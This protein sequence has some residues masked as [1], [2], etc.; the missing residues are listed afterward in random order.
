MDSILRPL[1]WRKFQDDNRSRSSGESNNGTISI[2]HSD[3]DEIDGILKHYEAPPSKN[4]AL[5]LVVMDGSE[6]DDAEV[7]SKTTTQKRA[8][9]IT[10]TSIKYE[11][12]PPLETNS[13][14]FTTNNNIHRTAQQQCI[15]EKRNS[16]G[17]QISLPRPSFID[18]IESISSK[19]TVSKIYHP[20][21]NLQHISDT[22]G[23]Y[24]VRI[25]KG[26]QQKGFES[27]LISNTSISHIDDLEE[28]ETSNIH[29]Q[30][31]SNLANIEICNANNEKPIIQH[32]NDFDGLDDHSPI[33]LVDD[34]PKEGDT[35]SSKIVQPVKWRFAN[36]YWKNTSTR[37]YNTSPAVR[38]PFVLLL[39]EK[40]CSSRTAQS[41]EAFKEISAKMKTRPALQG[42]KKPVNRL[43][44][45]QNTPSHSHP[46]SFEPFNLQSERPNKK[47][48]TEQALLSN[49]TGCGPNQ[50]EHEADQGQGPVSQIPIQSQ[51]NNSPHQE[52]GICSKVKA[53]ES[54]TVAEYQAVNDLVKPR[55]EKR[56]RHKVNSDHHSESQGHTHGNAGF[57]AQ[58]T[59]NAK[60]LASNSH[61][62]D[63]RDPISNEEDELQAPHSTSKIVPQVVIPSSGNSHLATAHQAPRSRESELQKSSYVSNSQLERRILSN[64]VQKRRVLGEVKLEDGSEDELSQGNPPE[65]PHVKRIN[66]PLQSP[67]VNCND[68]EDD[69]DMESSRD[70]RGDMTKWGGSKN[71]DQKL[72]QRG[73]G[74]SFRVES[75]FS[76]TIYWL[77]PGQMENWCLTLDKSGVIRLVKDKEI[78]SDFSI[79]ASAI[80][81]IMI[82]RESCKLVIRKPQE[83]GLM[84]DADML[85]E[86]SGILA[87]QNFLESIKLFLKDAEV[88]WVENSEIDQRFLHARENLD[89]RTG[90]ALNKRSRAESQ[91]EDLQLLTSN[92]DRRTAQ[93]TQLVGHE[94]QH[95]Q[96]H[97]L[98]RAK[99]QKIH[100]KMQ[101]P[102]SQQ[103]KNDS[104]DPIE[105]AEFYASSSKTNGTRASLRSAERPK[106]YKPTSEAR[107]PSPERWSEVNKD[108]EKNWEKSV[109]YPKSGKKTATVDKQDIYRLDNGEFLNDNLIMFYLLWLEQQHPEL[110]TRV[111]VH[112]TF[113][114]ASL[115]KA[116]KNKKGINYEA[117]E[118]WTAKVDLLSYDYIIVPVNENTHWYVAIICN[119]PRLLNLEIK[120]SPQPIE[121]DV[122]SEQDGEIELRSASKLTTPS[123][124]PQS[125]PMRSVSDKDE[126]GVDDSFGELSLAQDKQTETPNDLEPAKKFPPSNHGLASASVEMNP[127]DTAVDKFATDV[128]D[129]AQ[130]SSPPAKSN[131]VAKGKRI[132]PIRTYDPK[133]PRIITFDSLALKHSNTCVNL[134]DYMVAEIKAKKS[135]SIIPPKPIGMAAKTQDKDSATG[136]YLGKGLPVQ[137][138]FCDCGVYLLSY[139]EEFFERPDSFIED[140]MEN[141]YEVDG[142]RNDAPAFRTKIRDILLK[143]QEEQVQ[144]AHAAK[145]IRIAK[146]AK[147][148]KDVPFMTA[149][150]TD[151]SKPQTA[152]S[153][154]SI[155]AQ[156]NSNANSSTLNER[157]DYEDTSTEAKD[158]LKPLPKANKVIN[159]SDSQETLQE[160]SQDGPN[161]ISVN[162][163]DDE[164]VEERSRS[165]VRGREPRQTARTVP[166]TSKPPIHLEIRDSQ[167]DE[168]TTQEGAD[169]QSLAQNP[170]RKPSV[171]DLEKDE[172]HKSEEPTEQEPRSGTSLIG[173]AV[174]AVGNFC[175]LFSKSTGQAA[176]Q[177]EVSGL[178]PVHESREDDCVQGLESPSRSG[179]NSPRQLESDVKSRRNGTVLRS[180][181]PEQRGSNLAKWTGSKFNGEVMDLTGGDDP[182]LLD[183]TDVSF[184]RLQQFPP[185]PPVAS[186]RKHDGS[187]IKTPDMAQFGR[188]KTS[189]GT[190]EPSERFQDSVMEGFVNNT[191]LLRRDPLEAKMIAQYKH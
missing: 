5:N 66:K 156:Q 90:Q 68:D 113:F 8:L 176:L 107:S 103:N 17:A 140:I 189:S 164:P 132:P 160:K 72:Q 162:I 71:D 46:R 165:R 179:M 65:V 125:T 48:K 52:H 177:G 73:H 45:A 2:P 133:Q 31:V 127:D 56:K 88:K 116:A 82:G 155:V 87:S 172:C 80:Q 77:R 50:F 131:S 128:I 167:E 136:R 24:E 110:S 118:R 187:K 51:Y 36:R 28:P 184:S 104:S 126:T 62:E 139:I 190:K 93:R 63:I 112:N 13:T 129:L 81:K 120:Q 159:I 144:E 94:D 105:P 108:W 170:R 99:R 47:Q 27:K 188:R 54:Y 30:K 61:L 74:K 67:E 1:I 191:S 142:D 122:Q 18:A 11:N 135:M 175:N 145:M 173:N 78:I 37:M 59:T 32:I 157:H 138:N 100:E 58:Q 101:I 185:S 117:V 180:P 150:K 39:T 98:S 40:I 134:K 166:N 14:V 86:F 53:F 89:K 10:R 183:E 49:G 26:F 137:G 114:Y 20:R 119:A 186:S 38:L 16:E 34:A 91:P 29:F 83:S 44:N 92:Q 147:K 85:I 178:F 106:T 12:I 109:V 42:G 76:P 96:H 97:S 15:Y 171:I 22:D 111:Y 55:K 102:P 95:A 152:S 143:L 6:S 4:K 121:N 153:S 84:K 149:K 168:E 163:I 115:T 174:N 148:G 64:S 146:R 154:E 161:S 33:T 69:I 3:A 130:S 151:L 181:S 43:G 21:M 60:R 23:R 19:S 158:S 7:T 75:L 124:S 79:K 141:K 70:R 25:D 182:M 57:K 41:S 123:K 35:D 169:P 9:M